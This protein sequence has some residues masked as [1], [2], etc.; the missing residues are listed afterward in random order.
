MHTQ[1]SGPA[2]QLIQAAKYMHCPRMM[3]RAKPVQTSA[4]SE[5]ELRHSLGWGSIGNPP[6]CKKCQIASYK[7]L[8]NLHLMYVQLRKCTRAQ[9]KKVLGSENQISLSAVTWFIGALKVGAN[10]LNRTQWQHVLCIAL[11]IQVKFTIYSTIVYRTLLSKSGEANCG[12]PN[13][14]ER[15][16]TANCHLW[17][18]NGC[19]LRLNR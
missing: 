2:L 7:M 10:F 3:G 14:V 9:N 16:S 17:S 4:Q 1:D 6:P 8:A 19:Y 12:I 15:R 13:L 18:S 5:L 11:K